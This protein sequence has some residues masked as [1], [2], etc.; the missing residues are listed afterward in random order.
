[1]NTYRRALIDYW[2]EIGKLRKENVEGSY[3]YFFVREDG[4]EIQHSGTWNEFFQSFNYFNEFVF[5]NGPM[6]DR[7]YNVIYTYF[8][9]WTDPIFLGLEVDWRIWAWMFKDSN[10]PKTGLTRR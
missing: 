3:R 8:D 5:V 6:L 10:E 7:L 2:M 4:F 9:P 1:M